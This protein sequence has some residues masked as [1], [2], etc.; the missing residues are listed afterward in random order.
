MPEPQRCPMCE[1]WAYHD[2]ARWR[3]FP[4]G[5]TPATPISGLRDL[6]AQEPPSSASLRFTPSCGGYTGNPCPTCGSARMRRNGTC[7]VC[8][9]CGTTTGCS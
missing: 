1:G 7:E 2:G 8:D 5:G 4:T 6:I 3:S 9:D